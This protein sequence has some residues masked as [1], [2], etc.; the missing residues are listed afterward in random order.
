MTDKPTDVRREAAWERYRDTLAMRR[1]MKAP[2]PGDVRLAF[3]AGYAAAALK[4]IEPLEAM[5]RDWRAKAQEIHALGDAGPVMLAVA[6]ELL[7]RADDLEH[8]LRWR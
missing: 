6:H 5:V 7:A 8:A 1:V 4:D 2:E 3:E